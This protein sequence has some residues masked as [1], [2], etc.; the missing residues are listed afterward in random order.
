MRVS[1]FKDFYKRCH[2]EISTSFQLFVEGQT[3]R[4]QDMRHVDVAQVEHGE[5]SFYARFEK[6]QITKE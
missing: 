4:V 6:I 1:V 3:F 2:Y 5:V